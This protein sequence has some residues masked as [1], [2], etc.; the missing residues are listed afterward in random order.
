MQKLKCWLGLH[1]WK[2]SLYGGQLY[3]RTCAHC[4]KKAFMFDHKR[5]LITLQCSECERN[6]EFDDHVAV[7]LT[8]D[9]ARVTC[10][11]DG[12]AIEDN[13]QDDGA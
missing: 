4:A 10:C 8:A 5:I 12:C 6:L 11:C 7:D 13:N 2:W 1:D 3:E 9:P